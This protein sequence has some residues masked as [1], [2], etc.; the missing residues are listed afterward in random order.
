M[1][2][3]WTN[4]NHKVYPSASWPRLVLTTLASSPALTILACKVQCSLPETT[5]LDVVLCTQGHIA[6][7]L[8]KHSSYEKF[9]H[10]SSLNC[11]CVIVGATSER[12]TVCFHHL[13]EVFTTEAP[14]VQ[15]AHDMSC[16]EASLVSWLRCKTNTSHTVITHCWYK[17]YTFNTYLH[18]EQTW[19]TW[20]T[21]WTHTH[22][23]YKDYYLTQI[24]HE[25][26]CEHLTA[27]PSSINAIK[28][29][30]LWCWLRW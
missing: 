28:C 22:E 15:A 27:Q 10:C 16:W 14:S 25:A 13:H 4:D 8:A 18:I 1:K 23:I 7:N 5:C 9:N 11:H 30:C 19:T 12:G 24:K 29:Q 6:L 3:S 17:Y 21:H 2:H 20:A 26:I